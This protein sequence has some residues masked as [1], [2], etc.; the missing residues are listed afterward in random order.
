MWEG[1][2][3]DQ[4]RLGGREWVNA[5]KIHHINVMDKILKELIKILY[6]LKN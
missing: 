3:A 6:I 4:G 5:T 2:A 1:G